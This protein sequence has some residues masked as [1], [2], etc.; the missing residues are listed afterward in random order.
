MS[1]SR[2]GP[3]VLQAVARV[4]HFS[5]ERRQRAVVGP[6]EKC[7]GERDPG[8]VL[9]LGAC[10]DAGTEAFL[11]FMA[12]TA[13]G[14]QRRRE[15]LDLVAEADGRVER[16]IAQAQCVVQFPQRFADSHRAQE[17]SVVGPTI[18][19]AGA[20]D[21]RELGRR[22]PRH[23]DER[24]IVGVALHRDVESR[25]ELLDEPQLLH[26]RVELVGR[27]VPGDAVRLPQDPG[28]LVLRVRAA[29]IAEQARSHPFGLADVNDFAAGRHHAIHTGAVGGTR[30]H[31]VA[32]HLHLLIRR[33]G[34]A[35]RIPP[36][37]FPSPRHVRYAYRWQWAQNTV[38]RPS[39][40]CVPMRRAPQRRQGSPARP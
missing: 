12:D 33:R 29:E 31:R 1:R 19:T 23:L 3:L 30:P 39:T 18:V 16:A 34:R 26:E 5:R 36:G 28:A 4:L 35:E 37:G 15:D 27:V 21:D 8:A 10:A 13:G 38:A 40:A 11:D 2:R 14:S 24:V 17:R 22:A 9:A 6:L 25:A 32:H 20:A 7:A